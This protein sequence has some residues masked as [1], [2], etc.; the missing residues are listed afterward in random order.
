MRAAGT[1]TRRWV[2]WVAFCLSLHGCVVFRGSSRSQPQAAEESERI[3]PHV[4]ARIAE[5]ERHLEQRE[6]ELAAARAELARRGQGGTGAENLVNPQARGEEKQGGS[7]GQQPEGNAQ[8]LAAQLA[9]ERLQRQAL[10]EELDR[11]RQEVNAPFGESRVA[12]A[13]Y[14]ALKQELMELRR[15]VR[16]QEQ[17]QRELMLKLAALPRQEATSER[18]D[19]SAGFTSQPAQLAREAEEE[20]IRS[21]QRIVELEAALGAAKKQGERSAALEA[22][23]DSLRSQ[24]AEERRRAEALEA[25]LRVAARVT[26]LI[27]RMR[28]QGQTETQSVPAHRE[29]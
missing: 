18:A 26:D 1:A 10:L 13:D 9:E 17:Q 11:L 5:L 29:R 14:L 24:L 3:P 27:F 4:A 22:E 23:N 8:S 12:E 21:R 7:G 20:L 16:Q 19:P 28:T 25:K 6:R 15:V 2:I